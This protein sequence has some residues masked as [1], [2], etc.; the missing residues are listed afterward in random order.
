MSSSTSDRANLP[1]TTPEQIDILVRTAL[2]V[3]D[4]GATQAVQNL[5]L[6]QQARISQLRRTAATTTKQYGADS[7][8]AK[9]AAAA[10]TAGT[11]RVAS[12]TAVHLQA[13]T[14]GPQV[15]P[16]GWALHGRVF[17]APSDPSS[18][19]LQPV[20]NL[21]VFLVDAQKKYQEQFGFAYTDANGYFI[22]NYAG[23]KSKAQA[24]GQFFVEI[25]DKKGRPF[26]LSTTRFQPVPGN[27]TYL[28]ITLPADKKPLGDPPAEIRGTAFP[29]PTRKA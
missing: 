20:P 1:H 2:G 6:V 11:A 23:S 13:A 4:S 19:Q 9:T 17:D 24:D 21:T 16:T 18:I 26:Y 14:P 28:N 10:V 8:E 15:S 22:L 7:A 12:M 27:A 25:A 5:T 3:G 29:N